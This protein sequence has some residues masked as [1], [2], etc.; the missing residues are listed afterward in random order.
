MPLQS[1]CFLAPALSPGEPLL[2]RIRSF[3]WIASP[4]LTSLIFLCFPFFIMCNYWEL[5]WPFFYVPTSFFREKVLLR[6]WLF[7]AALLSFSMLLFWSS[8]SCF[9][10]ILVF[11]TF[12]PWESGDLL[13]YTPLYLGG[14]FYT[15]WGGALF[16]ALYVWFERLS[17]L[18]KVIFFDL[19]PYLGLLAA[20]PGDFLLD[21]TWLFSFLNCFSC[22]YS[23][24]F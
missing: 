8:A 13:D 21:S 1:S 24:C 14:W 20:A 6:A 2:I 22:T 3:F 12:L 19:S 5:S 16:L 18:S 7:P 15:C 10:V 11:V 17:P 9:L 23:G 4:M